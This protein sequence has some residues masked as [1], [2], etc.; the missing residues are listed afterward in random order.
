MKGSSPSSTLTFINA[1]VRLIL[2]LAFIIGLNLT[3]AGAWPAYLLFFS[4]VLSTAVLARL[5]TGPLVLKSLAA[6]PFSLAALLL[7]FSGGEPLLN[8]PWGIRFSQPGLVRFFSIVIKACISLQAALVLTGVT[9]APDLLRA[10]RELGLPRVFVSIITLMWRYL[11]LL[12]D[13]AR[14]LLTARASR[15]SHLNGRSGG[16]LVWR[17]QVAGGMAGSL[18]LRGMERGDRVYAAMLAR[19]YN[20]EP[21]PGAAAETASPRQGWILAGGLGLVILL[22]IFGFLTAARF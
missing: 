17:A 6:L 15:S 5:K 19:G 1:R 20:G 2:I 12:V 16:S 4:L 11:D 14:R 9:P 3:P 18:L 8:G 10:L 13:E 22:T 7:I 21:L